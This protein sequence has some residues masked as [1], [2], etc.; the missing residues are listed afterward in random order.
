MSHHPPSGHDTLPSA[1][2]SL[3]ESPHHHFMPAQG[4]DDNIL[5]ENDLAAAAAATSHQ[6]PA[7]ESDDPDVDAA[8]AAATVLELAEADANAN[9]KRGASQRR[10]IEKAYAPRNTGP[11][12]V[13]L[14]SLAAENERLRKMI[15]A[16]ER[17]QTEDAISQ[18][19]LRE[20]A[21]AAVDG[22]PSMDFGLESLQQHLE[23]HPRFEV[24]NGEPSDGITAADFIHGLVTQ[25]TE[26]KPDRRS[27]DPLVVTAR[28]LEAEIAATRDM[29]KHW[30]SSIF[31][32]KYGVLSQRTIVDHKS[33]AAKNSSLLETTQKNVSVLRELMRVLQA[34]HDQL[35]KEVSEK[36]TE[37]KELLGDDADDVFLFDGQKALME[38]RGYIEGAL[39]L[40][41]EV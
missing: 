1:L 25:V 23:N 4:D 13:T 30:E 5:M 12:D 39:K 16:L 24:P 22:G 32:K 19:T 20:L 10:P 6:S 15:A 9:F 17:R 34:D 31:A 28:A 11:L 21:A 37:L 27:E 7:P 35:Q 33:Q 41:N 18:A 29:I 2:S 3:F 26:D 40:W 36:T 8:A 14:G 38:V